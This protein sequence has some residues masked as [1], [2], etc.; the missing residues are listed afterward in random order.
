VHHREQAEVEHAAEQLRPSL[1]AECHASQGTTETL[2][3]QVFY[4]LGVRVLAALLASL[5]LP[6]GGAHW[7]DVSPAGHSVVVTGSPAT[8]SRC[9][10]YV[11][12]LPTLTGRLDRRACDRPPVS[13][14]PIVPVVGL[15]ADLFAVPVTV[16]GKVVMRFEDA[17]NTRPQYAWYGRSLWIYDVATTDGPEALRLDASTGALLQRTRMPQL[18][19]PVMV[20]DGDGLWLD[21]ATNGGINGTDVAA[22]LHV[23]LGAAKP[24][25]VHRG[26]RAAMWMA[27]SAHTVWLEQIAGRASA[28]LWRIDGTRVRLLAR[29]RTIAFAGVYGAGRLWEL[30]CGAKEHL[31]RLDPGTGAPTPVGQFAKT[32][33]YCD[34]TM[35]AAGRDVFVLEGRN[36]YV[37]G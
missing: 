15:G 5:T 17:S 13:A 31:L 25:V 23:P 6:L 27:A 29:P 35:T 3:W 19:R 36:L 10:F 11:V 33:S 18:Y 8:G 22:V 4:S 20:A 34:A 28:S 1:G 12:E 14:H 32:A 9:S 24:V 37:Y 2:A 7:W 30:T 21:P 26:G 16:A